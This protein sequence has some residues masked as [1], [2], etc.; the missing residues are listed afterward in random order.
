ML[1]KNASKP[2]TNTILT[3]WRGS[4][5][6]IYSGMLLSISTEQRPH[7]LLAINDAHVLS[8]VISLVLQMSINLLTIRMMT[9]DT[10]LCLWFAIYHW[11]IHSFITSQL[12]IFSDQ[13]QLICRTVGWTLKG[14]HFIIWMNLLTILSDLNFEEF[15]LAFWQYGSLDGLYSVASSHA[16]CVW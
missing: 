15:V 8:H 4:P 3:F 7:V 5:L 9:E 10:Y 6:C 12:L 14:L 2:R 13:W 16:V 1:S 11:I